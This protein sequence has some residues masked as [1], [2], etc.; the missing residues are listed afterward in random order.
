MPAT[1]QQLRAIAYLVAACRPHGCKQ[2]DEAG[3]YANLAKVRDR[4]L[5]SIT[6]AAIQ[7]AEDRNAAT[8]G[9]IA[10]PGPHWRA[11]EAAPTPRQTED[12]GLACATCGEFRDVCRTR[13]TDDHEYVPVAKT[14]GERTDDY[15]ERTKRMSDA[16]KDEIQP[17]TTPD[18]T[19][20]DRVTPGAGRERLEEA[21]A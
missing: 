1:D 9:V 20:A 12:P 5:A 7:A 15:R 8:P 19:T 13:W 17:T 16:V 4:S 21:S 10:A 6:I 3:I 18:T 14:R 2:W 11:P